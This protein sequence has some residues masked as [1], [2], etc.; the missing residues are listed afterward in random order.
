MTP[1]RNMNDPIRVAMVGTSWYADLA[2]LPILKSHPQA[3]VAAIC[4]RNRA[5][6]DEIAG[7]FGVPQ[8]FTDYEV[9]FRQCELDAAVIA[10]PDELWLRWQIPVEMGS[11]AWAGGAG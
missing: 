10:V 8:V 5:R 1:R 3:Q 2:H 4:G 7:K 6:A 11:P 9:M